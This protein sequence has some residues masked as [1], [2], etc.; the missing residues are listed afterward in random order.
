MTRSIVTREK[1]HVL[2]LFLL[3]NGLFDHLY[4]IVDILRCNRVLI[5]T[6]IIQLTSGKAF[7]LP[8]SY[9]IRAVAVSCS[10][11]EFIFCHALR[12]VAIH[13]SNF[14]IFCNVASIYFTV[15]SSASHCATANQSAQAN[16]S[17]RTKIINTLYLFILVRFAMN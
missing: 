8:T 13:H 12:A 10:E 11:V 6:N 14:R 4:L 5:V 1:M 15:L 9:I 7:L 2:L 16:P 17:P 3:I